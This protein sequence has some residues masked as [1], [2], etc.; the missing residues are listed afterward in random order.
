[1]VSPDRGMQIARLY[2]CRRYRM[3]YG[4][5]VAKVGRRIRISSVWI[6]HTAVFNCRVSVSLECM[7]SLD[8]GCRSVSYGI[9]KI[10]KSVAIVRKCKMGGCEHHYLAMTWAAPIHSKIGSNKPPKRGKWVVC[11]DLFAWDIAR[12]EHILLKL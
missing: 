1:M 11:S 12:K 6:H 3:V 9:M 5:E 4:I 2:D 8:G 10:R 7:I